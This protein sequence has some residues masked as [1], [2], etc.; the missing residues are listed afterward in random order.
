VATTHH[1]GAREAAADGQAQAR[2]AEVARGGASAC[3]KG[4]EIGLQP[5]GRDA[6]AAVGHVDLQQRAA[7]G[8]VHAQADAHLAPRGELDGVAHQVGDDLAQAV[9]GR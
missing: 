1:Q 5:V 3:T 7:W 9:Q 2:A 6:D 4:S 8:G